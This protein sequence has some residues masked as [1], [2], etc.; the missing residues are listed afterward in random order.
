MTQPQLLVGLDLGSSRI[1]LAMGQVVAPS[2]RGGIGAL[3][4]IGAVEAPSQG[5]SKGSIT[6]L[7]DAVAG[8]SS[9]LEQ[10]E[11]HI[12]APIEEAIVGLNGT[13][14][15][16]LPAKG[17]VGVSRPDG[18]IRTDDLERVLESAK[19]VAN[20][21][22]VEIIHVL[23]HGFTVDGQTGV[24][25]PLGMHGIRIEAD[26]HLVTGLAGN[27]RNLTKCVLRTGIDITELVFGPLAAANTVT[28]AR[29]RELGVAVVGIGAG[30]TSLAV[31]EDGEL[32]H[33][34]VL[35]IGA[36]HVTSD[37][38]I[39][40]RVSLEAAEAIK[41]AYGNADSEAFGKREEIDIG[42]FGADASELV[43]LRFVS[44]IIRARTEEIFEKIEAELRQ[45]D[46]SG[47]LPAGAVLTGGGAKLRGLVEVAKAT[48]R[49]PASIGAA[50]HLPTSIPE[51][52]YDPTFS[53]AVGLVQWGYEE[54]RKG[55]GAGR[56]TQ[57]M[58][59][60]GDIAGRIGGAIKSVF[61]S[62]VP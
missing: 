35:P 58:K 57:I 45:I 28:N 53:T 24:R 40:L 39:G 59:K 9:A 47:L 2:E 62:F 14:V 54:M 61:K 16:I 48:L 50:T 44:E 43:S 22:N 33:S 4:M 15:G 29:E 5:I 17:V 32:L 55:E 21:A 12:G 34:A 6:A 11:R 42:E 49:L 60:G 31:F 19:G 52:V 46:R 1:R 41:L 25:D 18:E 56:S 30:T 20:P 10:G 13:H 51:L 37:I 8:I 3:T 36:D 7:E 26:A 23:P 27:V 38:A